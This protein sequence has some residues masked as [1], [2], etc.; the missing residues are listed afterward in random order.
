VQQHRRACAVACEDSPGCWPDDVVSGPATVALE[1]LG[2]GH[3]HRAED[4]ID[5]GV[6]QGPAGQGRASR[7]HI[8]TE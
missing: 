4:A 5:L 7:R 6:A 1:L 8:T 2:G 3:G